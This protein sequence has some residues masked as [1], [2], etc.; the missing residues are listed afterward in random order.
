M[1]QR[2]AHSKYYIIQN[3]HDFYFYCLNF[4]EI[5]MMYNIMLV[6]GVLHNDLT[7]SNFSV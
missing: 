3:N 7:F 6:P 2:L 4:I 1:E 5:P